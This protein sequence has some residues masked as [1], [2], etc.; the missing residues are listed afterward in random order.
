[1]THQGTGHSN[2]KTVLTV[3]LFG[4]LHQRC[5]Y[6]VKNKLRKGRKKRSSATSSKTSVP[7]REANIATIVFAFFDIVGFLG[8]DDESCFQQ[9]ANLGLSQYYLLKWLLSLIFS[10]Q[11]LVTV[12][13][14]LSERNLPTFTHTNITKRFLFCFVCIPFT[15]YIC[16]ELLFILR[17]LFIPSHQTFIVLDATSLYTYS[18]LG[19]QISHCDN[20]GH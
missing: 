17:F 8:N 13:V 15:V 6:N 20:S 14:N 4:K 3:Q 11:L 5:H 10:S 18:Q 7:V 16:R 12:H 2:E 9:I 1:M 19:F